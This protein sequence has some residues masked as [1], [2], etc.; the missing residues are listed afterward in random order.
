MS[1]TEA[2][3]EFYQVETEVVDGRHP[4]IVPFSDDGYVPLAY[5]REGPHESMREPLLQIGDVELLEREY[6][7]QW[8]GRIA[9]PAY[10]KWD[11]LYLRAGIPQ[12]F[13]MPREK[14]EDRF[15]DIICT[16]R[17]RYNLPQIP[18]DADITLS[19]YELAVDEDWRAWF[20]D[21]GIDHDDLAPL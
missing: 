18:D 3:Q 12:P 19:D 8:Y 14:L 6:S 2:E 20:W 16:E 17:D 15:E 21:N 10:D 9:T 11:A 5:V 1:S 7:G 13:D 4:V